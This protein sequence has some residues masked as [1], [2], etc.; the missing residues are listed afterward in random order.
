MRFTWNP[1][2][3]SGPQG[4]HLSI[5]TTTKICTVTGSRR[6]HAGTFQRTPPR[7]SYSLRRKPTR[8]LCRSGR[9]RQ[10]WRS[11]TFPGLGVG[12]MSVTLLL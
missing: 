4:S 11:L 3:A 10:K 5:C 6:A 8:K 1:S 9:Y 12:R 7:P 2:P